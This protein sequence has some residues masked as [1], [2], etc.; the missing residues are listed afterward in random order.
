MSVQRVFRTVSIAEAVTWTLLIAAMLARYA[1]DAEV[2]FFF[3]VGLAHG[4]A[5]IAYV[6]VV[7]IVGLNQRWRLR[8]V[9]TAALASIP[10][11]GTL[12][13]DRW[14]E[15]RRMLD[16]GWRTEPTDDPRDAQPVDRL[17]RWYLAR[18]LLLLATVVAGVALVTGVLL[19]I[20]PPGR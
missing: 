17:L 3:A 10:P 19:V 6:V 14:L 15:R 12:V 20:G 1:F 2:P 7:V 16:G 5:F 11:Y 9:L 4:V 18:P 13:M 8:V